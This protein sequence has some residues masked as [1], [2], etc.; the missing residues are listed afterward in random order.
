MLDVP[1]WCVVSLLPLYV[2]AVLDFNSSPVLTAPTSSRCLKCAKAGIYTFYCNGS[3]S[4]CLLSLLPSSRSSDLSDFQ[5]S[6]TQSTKS[7]TG[8]S[9]RPFAVK[10]PP[11][12]PP[13]ARFPL[14]PPPATPSSPNSATSSLFTHHPIASSRWTGGTLR[15]SSRRQ[16]TSSRRRRW[17]RLS[18]RSVESSSRLAI[19]AASMRFSTGAIALLL[20]AWTNSGAGVHLNAERKT[21]AKACKL[22]DGAAGL[23][24]MEGRMRAARE[25][26]DGGALPGF[27]FTKRLLDYILPIGC[28]LPSPAPSPDSSA[29]PSK[30]LTIPSSN[31][32]AVSTPRLQTHASRPSS[33]SGPDSAGSL[34]RTGNLP[35]LAT[36]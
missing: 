10:A 7:S 15:L 30:S 36:Q 2:V 5:S 33:D 24:A 8:R 16:K 17:S 6:L 3:V 22:G 35:S 28:V 12:S 34:A 1:C 27:T 19:M 32:R 23:R 25:A 9:T 31:F 14:T 29:S 26:I 20:K 4:S 21:I 11:S 18:P 13:P